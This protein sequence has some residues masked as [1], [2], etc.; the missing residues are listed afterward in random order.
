MRSPTMMPT[1]PVTSIQDMFAKVTGKLIREHRAQ[2][3][4]PGGRLNV[5]VS[6]AGT[7]ITPPFGE[8]LQCFEIRSCWSETNCPPA[9]GANLGDFWVCDALP[10]VY[11]WGPASNGSE[12]ASTS[13]AKCTAK[14]EYYTPLGSACTEA[15]CGSGPGSN[16]DSFW[17]KVHMEDTQLEKIMWAVASP[18]G[19]CE[20]K[21]AF[22]PKW[23]IGQWVWCMF[24][25]AANVWRVIDAYDP[26]IRFR[27]IEPLNGCDKA[28]AYVLFYPCEKCKETSS[29]SGSSSSMIRCDTDLEPLDN[30]NACPGDSYSRLLD[31]K[32]G[33]TI[34]GKLTWRHYGPEGSSVRSVSKDQGAFYWTVPEDEKTGVNHKVIVEAKDEAGCIYKTSW[35]IKI[36]PCGSMSRNGSGQWPGHTRTCEIVKNVRFDATACKLHVEYCTI[37]LPPGGWCDCGASE[38]ASSWSSTSHHHGSS[39][40]EITSEEGSLFSES[41]STSS[42]MCLDRCLENAYNRG[43]V[44]VHDPA[45]ID[46]VMFPQ[47][48]IAPYDSTG[49][50]TWRADSRRFEVISYGMKGCRGSESSINQ[51]V[52]V[53]DR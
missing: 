49:W 42:S 17:E 23:S 48:G 10:V 29:S 28:K 35:T 36:V 9:N 46:R 20:W 53:M 16:L 14:G 51:D 37:H 4:E 19:S 40:H 26:I 7:K 24:D 1:G 39:S 18:N 52:S 45:G 25:Y 30:E 44:E 5:D 41:S 50:A 11:W 34:N 31:F 15:S 6:A 22:Y 13:I 12:S 27:L 8:T 21:Q 43:I 2:I 32:D 38:S 33:G 3:L 47:N